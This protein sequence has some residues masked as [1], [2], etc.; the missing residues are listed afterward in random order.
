MSIDYQF[1]LAPLPYTSVMASIDFKTLADKEHVVQG[2]IGNSDLMACLVKKPTP[3]QFSKDEL[4]FNPTCQLILS[5]NLDNYERSMRAL[6]ATINQ[7]TPVTKAAALYMNN[8]L[9]LLDKLNNQITLYT[10][11]K[12]WWDEQIENIRFPHN[13]R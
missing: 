2:E 1:Y 3:D 10:S 12:D 11:D 4:Q 6:I 8:E 9:L 5:P 7:L 13:Q